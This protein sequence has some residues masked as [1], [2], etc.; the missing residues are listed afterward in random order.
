VKN[1]RLIACLAFA[2]FIAVASVCAAEGF[3]EFTWAAGK[4]T[5][6]GQTFEKISLV[7]YATIFNMVSGSDVLEMK[8]VIDKNVGKLYQIKTKDKIYEVPVKII[9]STIAEGKILYIDL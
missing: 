5:Y 6:N 7:R 1:A 2:A 9:K 3:G 4:F 8:V